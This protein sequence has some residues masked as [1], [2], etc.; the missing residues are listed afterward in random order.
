DDPRLA[1]APGEQHLAEGVVQLVR[2]GMEQVLTF[3]PDLRAGVALGES[4]RERD[5]RRPAG[6]V[7]EAAIEIGGECRIR[8]GALHLGLELLERW[9]ERLG[10]GRA[11]VAVESAANVGA[12][13]S[14]PSSAAAAERAATTK[15]RTRAGSLSPGLRSSRLDA[16]T[17]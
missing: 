7:R 3:E 4:F 16:S 17:P 11:A 5:R 10:D 12:H 14:A 15:S 8:E 1:H 2:A 6:E 13:R 9:D